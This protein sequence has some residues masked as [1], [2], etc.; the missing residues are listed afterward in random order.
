MNA[1]IQCN[2]KLYMK[3]I[4]FVA[5]LSM[6]SAAGARP[7]AIPTLEELIKKAPIVVIIHPES[8]RQTEDRPDD[9]SFGDRD[10]KNYDSL[11]TTCKVITTFKGS[12][13]EKN[14]KIIHFAYADPKP[15]FNGGLMMSFLFNPIR[16]VTFPALPN[17]KPDLTQGQAY[18]YGGSEYLAYLRLLPDGR[19]AAVT[20]QYDAAAS[21]YLLSGVYGAQRYHHHPAAKPAEEPKK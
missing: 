5:L 3:N 9:D 21:F 20:P 8:I 17:G 15:E 11:E 6:V 4:I 10:L 18:G 1:L 2:L 12:V 7:I 14:I 13:T 16:F 19:Y